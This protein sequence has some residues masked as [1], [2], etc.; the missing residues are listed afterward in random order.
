L[1]HLA[2]TFQPEDR[3]RAG[4]RRIEPLALEQVGAVHRGGADADADVRRAERRRRGFAEDEHP[5][6]ARLADE[7][8][9]HADR[10]PRH[11]T[12]VNARAL[13]GVGRASIR[14]ACVLYLLLVCAVGLA[15]WR[16]WTRTRDVE[17]QV[18]ELRLLR[19]EID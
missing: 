4:R 8:R 10:S 17:R 3:R 16:V 2:R 12:G 13:D 18:R 19:R 6:V 1:G 7:D 9:T 11:V 14:L 15:V 5:L